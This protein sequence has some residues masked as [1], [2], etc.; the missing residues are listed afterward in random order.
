M[1]FR[2]CLAAIHHRLKEKRPLQLTPTVIMLETDLSNYAISPLR[3]EE[4]DKAEAEQGEC[5]DEE[6]TKVTFAVLPLQFVSKSI[7]QPDFDY[8]LEPS[9]SCPKDPVSKCVSHAG[10]VLQFPSL[11]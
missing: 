5:D 4:A 1:T 9:S 6:W 7:F 11:L 8:L 2:A 3:N 10:G